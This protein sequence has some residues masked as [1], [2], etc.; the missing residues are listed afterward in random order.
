[1]FDGALSG[2]IALNCGRLELITT[3]SESLPLNAVAARTMAVVGRATIRC[4]LVNYS[5]RISPGS[6]GGRPL[7]VLNHTGSRRAC[8][9]VGCEVRQVLKCRPPVP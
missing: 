6:V 4:N 7:S 3:E 1:M 5:N 9:Q 8:T 2:R